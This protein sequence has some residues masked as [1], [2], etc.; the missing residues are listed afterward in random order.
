MPP[1]IL[2]NIPPEPLESNK[3]NVWKKVLYIIIGVFVLLIAFTFMTGGYGLIIITETVRAPFRG[4][5]EARYHS[6]K[7]EEYA[8]VDHEMDGPQFSSKGP[9][10]VFT[11]KFQTP[12]KENDYGGYRTGLFNFESKETVILASENGIPNNTSMF[13]PNEKYLIYAV[14]RKDGED[15]FKNE[16][17]NWRNLRGFDLYVRDLVGNKSNLVYSEKYPLWIGNSALGEYGFGWLDNDNIFYMCADDKKQPFPGYCLKNIKDNSFKMIP[18][19]IYNPTVPKEIVDA[20]K[21]KPQPDHIENYLNSSPPG[22]AT[23]IPECKFGIY[24]G[25]G[26]SVVMVRENGEEKFLFNKKETPYLLRWG[27]DD[28]LY[29]FLYSGNQ[30]RVYKLY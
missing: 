26:V 12:Y 4:L 5:V 10:V 17:G 7:I 19:N 14:A 22:K 20:P 2:N 24:D 9:F 3:T 25:C 11:E 21:S 27:Y 23:L 18:A 28:H 13:S 15:I 30:T 1:P 6:P 16:N 8:A 29:G